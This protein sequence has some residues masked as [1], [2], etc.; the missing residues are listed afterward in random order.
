MSNYLIARH[1]WNAHVLVSECKPRFF[2]PNKQ[3]LYELAFPPGK[4]SEGEIGYTRWAVRLLPDSFT[5]DRLPLVIERQPGF[6]DYKP[7][8]R[9]DLAVWHMNF[10]NNDAFSSWGNSLFAQDEIQVAEHPALIALRMAATK[11]GI[12]MFCIE[13]EEPT[14]ILITGVE[15]RLSIS[16]TPSPERPNGLYGNQFGRAQAEDVVAATT[17]LPL[18]G[19]TNL[20]VIEAP[21]DGSGCYSEEEIGFILRT[22]FS[23]FAAA[24]EMSLDSLQARDVCIHTGFWGCGAYGGNRVL[25]TLL[26]MIAADLAEVSQ[27]VFH[28]GD[29][30]G[31]IF[32][33]QAE[34]AYRLLK[35]DVAI[36]TEQM[37]THLAEQNYSWGSSDGN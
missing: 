5:V 8:D 34:E 9:D 27:L 3:R 10:A 12:S 6:F 26:Q 11:S 29:S 1:Q 30:S 24:R 36:T 13:G 15:R 16:T 2:H 25:M 35:S 32:I 22:A 37:I 4:P 28:F 19:K 21:A 7:S 20:I 14:P 17:V 33:S 23:G 31:D 18:P